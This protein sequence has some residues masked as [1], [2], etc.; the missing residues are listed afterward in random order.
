MLIVVTTHILLRGES[1]W[2]LMIIFTTVVLCLLPF[3]WPIWDH[4][5]QGEGPGLHKNGVQLLWYEFI[6]Y[7]EIASIDIRPIGWKGESILRM[8]PRYEK[9][10]IK[11]I[12]EPEPW[13]IAVAFMG[14]EGLRE[15]EAR[16]HATGSPE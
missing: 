15:L 6:P 7:T 12:L 13:T 2:P 8:H 1:E 4:L 14:E 3:C 10:E 11:G 9:R 5:T 16:V